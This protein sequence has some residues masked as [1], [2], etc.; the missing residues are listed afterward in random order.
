M[1]KFKENAIWFK[2]EYGL[3]P[4]L[5]IDNVNNIGASN[6]HMLLNLQKKAKEAIDKGF[7]KIVFVSSDGIVPNFME[8]KH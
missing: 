2:Q 6:S 4:T 1:K 5:V 3:A 8:G 7:F